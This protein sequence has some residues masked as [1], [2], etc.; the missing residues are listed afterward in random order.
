MKIATIVRHQQDECKH[1]IKK[2]KVAMIDSDNTAVA[3]T[4]SMCNGN[5]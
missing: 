2:W 4:L 1:L 3:S 5:R